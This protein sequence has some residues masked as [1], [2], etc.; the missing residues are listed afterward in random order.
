MGAMRK[1]KQMILLWA[2]L[3]LLLTLSAC[4]IPMEGTPAKRIGG[5]SPSDSF[6]PTR[7]STPAAL[8]KENPSKSANAAS[9]VPHGCRLELVYS[10]GGESIAESDFPQP[11]NEYRYIFVKM[12]FPNIFFGLRI[13][14]F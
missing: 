13:S 9:D 3:V 14:L 12:V 1:T 4:G 11:K 8:P 10:T 2:V 7:E 5:I 6:I